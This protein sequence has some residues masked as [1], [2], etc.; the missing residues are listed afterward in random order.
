MYVRVPENRLS[1]TV[2]KSISADGKL[3]PSLVIVP[4]KNI[5]MS[6]FYE[7]MIGKEIITVSLLSYTNK[8]I[9]LTWL[10]YF[11]KHNDCR[12]DQPW[13]ILLID[14]AICYKAPDFVIKAKMHCIWIVKF[15][16]Y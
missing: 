3:I 12:P 2:I 11:I 10:D 9:C 7:N 13:R 1:F 16:F 14:G 4:G 15:P 5:M 6:W 8:K